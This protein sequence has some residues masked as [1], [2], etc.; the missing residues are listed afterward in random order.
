MKLAFCKNSPSEWRDFIE[1]PL[2]RVPDSTSAASRFSYV[3]TTFSCF[4]EGNFS[5]KLTHSDGVDKNC[6]DHGVASLCFPK[7]LPAE[8]APASVAPAIA[9]SLQLRCCAALRISRNPFRKA[10]LNPSWPGCPRDMGPPGTAWDRLGPPGAGKMIHRGCATQGGGEQAWWRRG[11]SAKTCKNQG[12]VVDV[13]WDFCW[14]I[15]RFSSGTAVERCGDHCE[16]RVMARPDSCDGTVSLQV[17]T[18][19]VGLVGAVF[20]P[21]QNGCLPKK[22]YFYLYRWILNGKPSK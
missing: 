5:H 11:R 18:K 14:E 20:S 6:H 17:A 3:M 21:I 19:K 15:I 10:W 7:D 2:K 4:E 1:P 8:T 12:W 9:A 22:Q 16:V 13:E